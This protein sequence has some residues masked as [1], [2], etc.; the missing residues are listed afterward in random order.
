MKQKLIRGLFGIGLLCLTVLN[1][2]TGQAQTAATVS[3]PSLSV[4]EGLNIGVK[5]SISGIPGAGLSDFQGFLRFDPN[6]VQVSRVTGLNGY[7]VFASQLDNQAGEAR[8]VVAKT[9][10]PF[11]Q[12]GE[13]L[14]FSFTPVG[15]VGASSTLNATLTTFNDSNG[16]FIPHESTPGRLTVVERE[17]LVASF[18]FAPQTGVKGQPVQFSNTTVPSQGAVIENT[19]WNFGDGTTSVEQNPTHTYT[20]AGTFTVELNVTDNFGR[21]NATTQQITVLESAPTTEGVVVARTFPQPASTEVT[22]VY[23]VPTSAVRAMLFVFDS[24]GKQVFQNNALPAQGGRFTWNLLSNDET[25]I[26]NGAYFYVITALGASG[27]SVGRTTGKI[28]VQK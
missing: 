24:T 5:M 15:A 10:A 23:Q 13:I 8:F 22:F 11:L 19:S 9:N 2:S 14:E 18:T 12:Q 21:N 1:F 28:I 3:L 20:Q 7:T 25:T 4:P 17:P 26:S 27:N 6:V 16:V